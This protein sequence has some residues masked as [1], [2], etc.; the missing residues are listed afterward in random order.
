MTYT[1]SVTPNCYI[2]FHNLVTGQDINLGKAIHHR[3][4]HVANSFATL[5]LPCT[6][7]TMAL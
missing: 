3:M 2:L 6:I 4:Q 7:T 5:T 1:H